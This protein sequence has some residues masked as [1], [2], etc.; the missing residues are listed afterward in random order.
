MCGVAGVLHLDGSPA[1]P[2]SLKRMTDAVAHRGPDGEGHHVDGPLGLGHRRLAIIDLSPGGKQPMATA[3]GR[4]V[5]TYNGELY[6]FQELRAELEKLGH[7]FRSRSDTEVLLA[8]WA[9][10]GLK[11]LDRMNG[12]FA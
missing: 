8:A 3:D 12:M 1:S 4:Y 6:N 5:V 2:V 11:A 7:R 10:W 9:Q